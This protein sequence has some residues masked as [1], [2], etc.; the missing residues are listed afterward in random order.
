MRYLS[1]VLALF[2]Y[3]ALSNAAYACSC[4]SSG[5]YFVSD[6]IK[7]KVIFEGRVLSAK[8]LEDDTEN[9]F[10]NS[11]TTF[12]TLHPFW[13]TFNGNISIYHHSNG[14]TCGMTFPMGYE[15]LVIAYEYK[16]DLMQTDVCTHNLIPKITIINYFEKGIDIYI[17]KRNECSETQ[18]DNPEDPKNCYFWSKEAEEERFNESWER[19]RAIWAKEQESKKTLNEN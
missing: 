9:D 8:W 12:D 13:N 15:T 16:Q 14:A 18:I 10:I 5:G 7:D 4:S 1:I 6:F 17:P 3:A 11:E 19:R 2:I